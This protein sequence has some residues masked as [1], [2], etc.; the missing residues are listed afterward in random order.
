MKLVDFFCGCG[1]FSL[2]AHQ[3]GFDVAAA[4]DIDEIL[5]S[6][7]SLN[8]PDTR[9]FHRD[10]AE[11]SGTEVREAIGEEIV[12]IFGGPPCQGFSDIGKRSKDDPRRELLGHFFRLVAELK[13]RFF[14]MEN[15]R[16]LAYADALPVLKD[17]LALV[18]LEYDI[19]GPR[20]WDASDFG[21][22]TK[23][24]R[25]FV[26][27]IRKDLAAPIT[28]EAFESFK[29][30]PISVKAAIADLSGALPLPDSDGLP[31]YDRWLIRRRGV[32][33]DYAL[34][35]RSGDKI[36]TGHRPTEHTQAVVKRFASVR[37]GQVDP[38]GRHPRLEWKGQC[39]TLRAGTGADKG[40]YQSVRPIHPE[41]DRVITVREAARLQGF[42]D[43]HLFH[44]TVWHSFRMIGNSVSPI[45][46]KAIF[47]ALGHHLGLVVPPADSKSSTRPSTEMSFP[48][49]AE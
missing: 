3:A 2:G 19:L 23:R 14:V 45:M 13:P 12:G 36:F 17:A 44:P 1:G 39:P 27:G 49:A 32:P 40:S 6:S 48:E 16:G 15:V 5:T 37:P 41:A 38:V 25:M 21:A 47:G 7:Y 4:Y 46:A 43:S 30:P 8:F 29:R 22:A 18:E 9:L 28:D 26:I 34:P 31:G 20:I 24:N 42:P 11:L 10:V 33:S 35:L